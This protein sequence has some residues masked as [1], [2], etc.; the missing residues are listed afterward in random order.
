MHCILLSGGSG[1]R[2][3]PL[4][5]ET[6]SKQFLK[7]LNNFKGENISMVQKTWSQIEANSMAD[8]TIIATSKSQ[9]DILKNQ[10]GSKVPI[11][12][13]PERRDTFPAI[14]LALSYLQNEKNLSDD[15]IVTVLPVDSYVEDHFFDVIKNLEKDLTNSEFDLG[16]VGTPPTYASEKYGYIIPERVGVEVSKVKKFVEKPTEKEAAI[17][18]EKQAVWNCG[19]FTFQIKFLRKIVEKIGLNFDYSWL[20]RNFNSL[21]QNS[22]D[23]EVLERGSNFIVRNYNGFWKD[24][25]TWNTVTEEMATN[26]VGQGHIDESCTNTHLINELDIPAVVS[27]IHNAIVAI[28]P[29]GILVSDKNSNKNIKELIKNFN[30]PIMYEERRWGWSKTLEYSKYDENN[31]MVTKKIAINKGKNSSYHYH[32]FR[33]ESWTVVKGEGEVIID[34]K[35]GLIERGDIIKIPL[36]T[37]HAVKATTDL[38]IIEVQYGVHINSEDISRLSFNWET[39]QNS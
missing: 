23:Y 8:S 27:N 21:P 35:I 24:L 5:N 16:L 7:L 1:K 18:L 32:N 28:S 4:S 34:G 38:E 20:S 31:E 26:Q 3:W 13:E 30:Q 6:R 22:F 17:L 29:D 12:I 9:E 15:E 25:G 33:E 14:V 19:I 2:L 11:V 39:I 37:K 10:L 36:N